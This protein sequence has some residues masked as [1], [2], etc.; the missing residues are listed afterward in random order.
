MP[1]CSSH[2]SVDSQTGPTSM[3]DYDRKDTG[4]NKFF[5]LTQYI[6]LTNRNPEIFLNKSLFYPFLL[7]KEFSALF[8]LSAYTK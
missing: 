6:T 1:N 4:E 8:A 2:F 3:R 7:V 5:A